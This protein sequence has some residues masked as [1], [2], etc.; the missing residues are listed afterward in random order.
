[1]SAM[2]ANVGVSCLGDYIRLRNGK[3]KGDLM[4][5]RASRGKGVLW[6][7]PFEYSSGQSSVCVENQCWQCYSVTHSSD[8]LREAVE[9]ASKKEA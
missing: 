5:R 9:N 8:Q 7:Y 6:E 1:M 2:K 4:D 3:Q